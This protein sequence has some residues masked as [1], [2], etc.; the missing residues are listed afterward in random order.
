MTSLNR[1]S[2]PWL[3]YTAI[4]L[5]AASL[6]LHAQARAV[7]EIARCVAGKQSEHY[8]CNRAA[9]QHV[10]NSA[11]T[12]RIDTDRLD[13]FASG[14]VKSL[15]ESLGKTVAA[16]DQ[17]ADLVFDL[18]PVDRSGRLVIGPGDV[19]LATLSVSV[20]SRGTGKSSQVWVETFDGQQDR[21]WPSIV[22]ELLRKFKNDALAH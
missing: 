4:L 3:L 18:A 22:T 2:L 19:S 21:P 13:L 16:S 17:H 14:Q 1:R 9:F 15:V 20:P 11:H 7:P 8:Q 10:L 6:S 5:V 12:V